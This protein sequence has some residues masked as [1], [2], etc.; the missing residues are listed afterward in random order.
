M[1]SVRFYVVIFLFLLIGAPCFAQIS[2]TAANSTIICGTGTHLNSMG[3]A[4]Y[5][6]TF[7]TDMD[8]ADLP[9]QYV[10]VLIGCMLSFFG[11]VHF[12]RLR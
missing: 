10:L 12:G 8:V 1:V 4:C 11:G 3:T 2:A 7:D 6:D 5:S 9:G